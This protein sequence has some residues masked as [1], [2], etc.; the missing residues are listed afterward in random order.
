MDDSS[1]NKSQLSTLLIGGI[2]A[3][4]FYPANAHSIHKTQ[5]DKRRLLIYAA[6]IHIQTHTG[7]KLIYAAVYYH[8]H[9]TR[10]SEQ[11]PG[12]ISL[13]DAHQHRLSLRCLSGCHFGGSPAGIL[14]LL[15][16]SSLFCWL[17]LLSSFVSFHCSL[18]LPFTFFKHFFSVFNSL[19]GFPLSTFFFFYF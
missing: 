15:P 3:S 6:N 17:S 9:Q 14:N 7:G 2:Q 11:K 5:P 16:A 1:Q 10:C 19:H 12:C 8:H 18:C 13:L 4:A